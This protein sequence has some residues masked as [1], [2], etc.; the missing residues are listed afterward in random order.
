MEVL[1]FMQLSRNFNHASR[2]L[3]RFPPESLYAD[4]RRA[5]HSDELCADLRH[6]CEHSHRALQLL[7]ELKNQTKQFNLLA[8][9]RGFSE[10]CTQ[11]CTQNIECATDGSEWLYG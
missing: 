11:S 9:I 10:I 4:F 6:P 8:R 5:V 2:P 3:T 7:R 1:L